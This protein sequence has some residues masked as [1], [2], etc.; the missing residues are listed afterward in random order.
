METS[1]THPKLYHRTARAVKL[2]LLREKFGANPNFEIVEIRDIA[3]DD[4]TGA[5]QGRA[6]W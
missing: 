4:F 1:S 2:E 5:L 6:L 3:A